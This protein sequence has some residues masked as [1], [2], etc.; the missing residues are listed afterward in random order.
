MHPKAQ[1]ASLETLPRQR[2]GECATSHCGC[3]LEE[4]SNEAGPGSMGRQLIRLPGR[5]L[6]GL[7]LLLIKF[8]QRF[9]SPGLAP[10]C[11]FTPSCSAYAAQALGKDGLFKGTAK[12][13]W[14]VLRCN[15]FGRGGYDPP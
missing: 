12:A 4:P 14:R 10:R 5:A 15:P 9:I 1:S 8:Y 11:R 3:D 7:L 6:V 13:T 2:H